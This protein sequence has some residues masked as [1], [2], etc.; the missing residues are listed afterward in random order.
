MGFALLIV[1]AIIFMVVIAIFHPEGEGFD[2]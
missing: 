2:G 1:L